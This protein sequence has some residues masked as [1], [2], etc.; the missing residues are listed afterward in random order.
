MF[1]CLSK[2]LSRSN[3][4]YKD[5]LKQKKQWKIQEVFFRMFR[6]STFKKVTFLQR[7]KNTVKE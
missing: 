4:H 7:D 6:K 1:V 5:T 3:K 2:I